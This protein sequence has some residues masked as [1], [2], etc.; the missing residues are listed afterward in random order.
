[1][2][3]WLDRRVHFHRPQQG[4]GVA[5]IRFGA[6]MKVVYHGFILGL[7]G[8]LVAVRISR[9]VGLETG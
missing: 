4:E 3:A 1:M 6:Q 7:L 2:L 9:D 8:A 5:G